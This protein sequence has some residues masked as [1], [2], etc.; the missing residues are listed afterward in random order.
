MGGRIGLLVGFFKLIAATKEQDPDWDCGRDE[1]LQP[2]TSSEQFPP[3]AAIEKP[4][5]WLMSP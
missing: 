5:N 1:E 2:H 3:S 4:V